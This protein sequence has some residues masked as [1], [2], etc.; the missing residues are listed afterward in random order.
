MKTN[1]S[2]LLHST[3]VAALAM[4]A[5]T[6]AALAGPS[7]QFANRPSTAPSAAKTAAAALA[8]CDGCKTTLTWAATDRSPAGKGAPAARVIG[9]QHDC[10]GCAGGIV[11]AA[12]QVKDTMAHSKECAPRLCCK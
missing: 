10:T 11:A 9:K 6:A 8:K 2:N 12:G 5:F 3:L 1:S 4:G 7:T